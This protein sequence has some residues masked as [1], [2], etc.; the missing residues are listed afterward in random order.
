MTFSIDR[1][2]FW[3]NASLGRHLPA[4]VH[5]GVPDWSQGGHHQLQDC[6]NSS[7]SPLAEGWIFLGGQ[8]LCV[9]RG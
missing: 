4:A 5:T 6:W 3:G 1:A 9:R 8:C 7:A 2:G